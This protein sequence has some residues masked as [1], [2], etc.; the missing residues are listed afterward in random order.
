MSRFMEGALIILCF[1]VIGIVAA[2]ITAGALNDGSADGTQTTFSR[3]CGGAGDTNAT[4]EAAGKTS[5]FSAIKDVSIGNFGADTP[6][7][8]S[9]LWIVA[10]LFLL[11]AAAIILVYSFVPFTGF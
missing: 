8:V 7:I 2:F 1:L 5:F 10:G 11:S 6:P 4:C 9:V 3:Q